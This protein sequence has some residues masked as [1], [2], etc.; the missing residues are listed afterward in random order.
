MDNRN[1]KRLLDLVIKWTNH[2]KSR[3]DFEEWRE[4][5]IWQERHQAETINFLEQS[6]PDLK[7][8][9]ILDLGSGMGG[10]L[11]VMK[12][13]EY[14]IQGLEPNPDYREISQ[15]RSQR[16][17]FEVKVN[18]GCGENMPFQE[19]SFGFI[20]CSDV[21]EHCKNPQ[22][23]LR[24]SCRVL[25]P[26]GLMLVTVVNRFSFEDPHYRIKF[27]NWLPRKLGNF[28]AKKI[29]R[30]DNSFF[31]DNQELSNMHY[32]TMNGFEKITRRAGFKFLRNIS[33]EEIYQKNIVKKELLLKL[34]CRRWKYILYKQW[35]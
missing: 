1:E 6:I 30:K 13:R 2:F 27:V 7:K 9:K 16:Y 14:D 15:L 24:E 35:K 31:E 20:Y 4:K 17:G 3:R 5:R 32:F 19:E 28:I 34:Y 11:V 22:Q 18:V 25:K 26:E 23:L 33:K 12:K 21:L 29:T 10:F 8:R